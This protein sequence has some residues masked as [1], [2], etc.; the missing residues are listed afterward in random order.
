MSLAELTITDFKRTLEQIWTIELPGGG[1]VEATLSQV[2]ALGEPPRPGVELTRQAFSLIWRGP[3]Q[4][5]LPQQIYRLSHP[6][7]AQ[8]EVFL[9]P[10]GPDPVTRAMR[11]E[12]IFT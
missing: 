4:P 2:S 5:L 1:T 10:I 12:A 11:Y 3:P 9:V 8:L 7:Y 6:S